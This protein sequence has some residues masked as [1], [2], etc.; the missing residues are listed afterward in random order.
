MLSDREELITITKALDRV[1]YGIIMLFLNGIFLHIEF[2]IGIFLI[3]LKLNLNIHLVLI[4]G[5]L[6]KINLKQI[7]SNRTSN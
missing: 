1:F 7:Q 3:N 2:Y 6:I 5:G 4:H